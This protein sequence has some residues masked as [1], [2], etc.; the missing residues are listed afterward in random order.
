MNSADLPRWLKNMYALHSLK[1]SDDSVGVNRT[2]TPTFDIICVRC[3][4]VV[5]AMAF[6]PARTHSYLLNLDN[7]LSQARQ[8]AERHRCGDPAPV[9]T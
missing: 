1:W 5:R 2:D 3:N 8:I 6:D 9:F 7:C 4:A